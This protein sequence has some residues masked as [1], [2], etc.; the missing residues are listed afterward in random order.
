V[1]RNFYD[2]REEQTEERRTVVT[3]TVLAAAVISVTLALVALLLRGWL[4]DV[5]F[6]SGEHER[7]VVLVAVTVPA[8]VVGT[9]LRES[10]RLRFLAGHYLVS[11]FLTAAVG[12]GIGV[13]A[14]VVAD[15]G[16]DA[17]I[18]GLLAANIV[19]AV[20]GAAAMRR[21]LGGVVSGHELRR[22]LAYGLPI[23]PAALALWALSLVD[24]L[25]LSGLADLTEVGKYAAANRWASVIQFGTTGFLLALAPYLLSIYSENRE[26]EKT[27]RGR[28][29]TYMAFT[30]AAAG[31]FV[32][33][34]AREALAVLAPGYHDA[35]VAVG[36]VAFGWVAF[37]LASLLMA[38][39]SLARRTAYFAG[40]AGAAAL[41]NVGLNLVLIPEWGMVGAA[42]ATAAAY[43]AL[44]L[45]YYMV[46]QRV[47]PTPYEPR[48]VLAVLVLAAVWS[49]PGYVAYDSPAV[50]VLVK[51]GAL[52]GFVASVVMTR[53][54]G[55]AEFREL[56]RFLLGMG[57]V[58][59]RPA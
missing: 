42:L 58:S 52:A 4:S 1:Q 11:S 20:Y 9:L 33:L 16:V 47:Y 30:L 44:A 51:A 56:G 19:A 6:G 27:T 37:G 8:L 25:M 5:L 34:F 57:G 13:F 46:A 28:T 17:V 35:Y 14:V 38:G 48:K 41:L 23:V 7:I 45:L 3:T 15:A 40:L 31:L 10:M 54:I 24:R 50:D 26:L 2:Y 29:L 18:A 36:P 43:A 12:A 21:D 32:T 39:I 49:A 53:T 59:R 22:L 55:V